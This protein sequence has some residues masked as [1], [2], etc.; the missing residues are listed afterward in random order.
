MMVSTFRDKARVGT[1]SS[2]NEHYLEWKDPYPL[3]NEQ[4]FLQCQA[5]AK[6]D[7]AI[8]EDLKV[9]EKQTD[10][11][12][13]A[14]SQQILIAGLL[15]KANFLDVIQNFTVFEPTDGKVIKKIR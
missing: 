10:Y 5:D 12:T 3:T 14:N 7:A 4:V 2:R 9:A 1:I 8:Q 11:A 13:Q 6:N 15:N